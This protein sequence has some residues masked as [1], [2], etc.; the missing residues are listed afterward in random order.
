MGQTNSTTMTPRAGPNRGAPGPPGGW[1]P[2]AVFG[3]LKSW[4]KRRKTPPHQIALLA[5]V[6]LFFGARLALMVQA[7]TRLYEPEEYINLRLAAA[8]LGEEGAWAPLTP[9]PVPPDHVSGPAPLGAFQ[10]QDFDGG[11]LAAAIALVPVAA[12]LGL[13]VASVKLGALLWTGLV[14]W[15]WLAILGRVGGDRGRLIG[16]AVFAFGPATWVIASSVH[17]GNHCESAFG[18]P[19]V[20]LLGM[21]LRRSKGWWRLAAAVGLGL[22]AGASIWFSQLNLLAGGLALLLALVLGRARPWEWP[23]VGAGLVAGL[24]PRLLVLPRR[25]LFRFGAHDRTAADLI[26][27]LLGGDWSREVL[28]A[29]WAENPPL[30]TWDFEGLGSFP[31]S[32][33]A[34]VGLRGVVVACLALAVVSAISRRRDGWE[35]ALAAGARGGAGGGGGRGGGRGG[36]PR[37]C[38]CNPPCCWPVAISR[39]IA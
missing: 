12:V 19:L 20:L 8:V 6:V 26:D 10:F 17:W 35:L 23:L 1:G 13:S 14:L 38:C 24:L 7:P 4:L 37:P 2:A 32:A 16:A 5:C 3:R 27:G 29:T 31:W 18:P 30:A 25:D 33:Q 15:L 34:E 11:T 22:G 9:P 21:A 28:V 36:R 39:S